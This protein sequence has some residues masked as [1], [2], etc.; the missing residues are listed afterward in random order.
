V[1][2]ESFGCKCV[3]DVECVKE[4]DGACGG[5]FCEFVLDCVGDEVCFDEVV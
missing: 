4:G 1:V 2:G 5:D 3:D